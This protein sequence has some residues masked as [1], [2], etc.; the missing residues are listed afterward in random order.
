MKRF[1]W[2]EMQRYWEVHSSHL[3][4][5]DYNYDPDGL[6]NVCYPGASLWLNQYYARFQKLV[7]NKLFDLIPPRENGRALDVGCGAGRWCRF[8][9]EHGY[10]T[11]G[12]DLQKELTEINRK[13][14][15]DC[16]FICIPIQD[17]H[18]KERFNLIS[19]VTVLQHIP[20]EEQDTVIHKLRELTEDNGFAIVLENIQHQGQHVFSNTIEEWQ[21]KFHN[22]GFSTVAVQ[23]YDYSSFLR[24]DAHISQLLSM[25]AQGGQSD[26]STEESHLTPST[27]KIGLRFHFHSAHQI[28]QKLAVNFDSLLEPLFIERNTKYPTVHCDFLFKAY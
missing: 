3:A 10:Q 22:A 2:R 19:S 16:N 20:F 1:A 6:T 12:I 23:R 15:P 21:K 27:L 13:R 4:N 24:I 17:Y 28:I 25:V 14:Y 11:T 8:L 5:I 9:T 18:T 7:Y 26:C